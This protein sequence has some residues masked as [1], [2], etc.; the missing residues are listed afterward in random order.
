MSHTK[1]FSLLENDLKLQSL[2]K[3]L[4]SGYIEVPYIIEQTLKI[5]EDDSP[6]QNIISD[7]NKKSLCIMLDLYFIDC[8]GMSIYDMNFSK[9]LNLLV[10]CAF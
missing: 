7:V 2:V 6:F 5:L 1:L 4:A 9:L 8:Y 3:N 10:L